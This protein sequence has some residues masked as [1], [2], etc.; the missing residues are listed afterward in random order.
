MKFGYPAPG[1]SVGCQTPEWNPDCPKGRDKGPGDWGCRMIL[2]IIAVG[3]EVMSGDVSWE[4]KSGN[5]SMVLEADQTR[6]CNT[7]P[8]SQ[9]LSGKKKIQK[10]QVSLEIQN[11]IPTFP[12]C[13]AFIFLR[14]QPRL[15]PA[16]FLTL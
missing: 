3:L 10:A 4:I 9:S 12:H 1:A 13:Y 7:N 6:L 2:A 14:T 15:L 5:P 16:F 11:C 8:F